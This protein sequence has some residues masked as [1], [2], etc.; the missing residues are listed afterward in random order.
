MIIST[1]HS[2][3]IIGGE[4]R[5]GGQFARLFKKHGFTVRATG[6]KTKRQNE[7]ILRNCDI[8][9]FALPLKSAATMITGFSKKARRKDQLLLDLSSLKVNEVKAMLCG[10]GEVIGMHPLFGPSTDPKGET[11]ILCPARVRKETMTS[12]TNVLHRLGLKTVVMT[13]GEHDRFM[14][15]VQVIPHLKSLLMA[16]V[17]RSMKI[18]FSKVLSMCTPTYEME[19]NI[20]GRFLDDHPGLYMPIIFRNP[21]TKRIL[22]LMEKSVK[23]LTTLA[24]KDNLNAAEKRYSACRRFFEPHLNK[25]RSHSEACIRT[26]LSLSR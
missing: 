7:S 22:R 11:I 18:D 20:V 19:F 10:A 13:P 3:G 15:I 1:R 6:S 12:L 14:A 24:S 4:G 17:M 25:A 23:N 8:V 16:E 5:T 21:E 2:I 9:I 26:L